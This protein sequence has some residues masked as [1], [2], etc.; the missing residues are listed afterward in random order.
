MTSPVVLPEYDKTG[1]LV[2]KTGAT[3]VEYPPAML[4]PFRVDGHRVVNADGVVV[5]V[6]TDTAD[7]AAWESV[8]T[9][10]RGVTGRLEQD[11]KGTW[12]K[13]L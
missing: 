9:A 8:P 10:V 11:D 2:S 4:A 3:V 5:F 12:R 13:R 1:R 6:L 7:R